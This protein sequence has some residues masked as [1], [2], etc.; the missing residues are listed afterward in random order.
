M[1]LKETEGKTNKSQGHPRAEEEGG[2][3]T[4]DTWEGTLQPAPHPQFHPTEGCQATSTAVTLVSLL[5]A[6]LQVLGLPEDNLK[7]ILVHITYLMCD[8]G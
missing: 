6:Y 7:S 2:R 5:I 8:S 1:D 4:K 3:E